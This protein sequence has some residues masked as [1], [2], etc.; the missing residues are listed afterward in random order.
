MDGAKSNVRPINWA[1]LKT[2]DAERVIREYAQ[3]DKNVLFRTHSRTRQQ[4][5]DIT[6]TDCLCILRDGYVEPM[7]KL[8]KQG[9]W[10]VKVTKRLRGQRY[11][12]VVTIILGNG[13]LFVKTVMERPMKETSLH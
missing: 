9:E 5:R 13:K 3:D 8:N 2:D 6:R 10:E 7:P 12:T 1:S 4:E 11:A